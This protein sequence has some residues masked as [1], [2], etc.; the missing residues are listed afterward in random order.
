[1]LWS[2]A[3]LREGE[4]GSSACAPTGLLHAF[5]LHK[6]PVRVVA[7]PSLDE[8]PDFHQPHFVLF[9]LFSC[10]HWHSVSRQ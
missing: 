9:Y 5:E 4:A 6:T 3:L 1:M 7:P 10:S 8:L 2:G